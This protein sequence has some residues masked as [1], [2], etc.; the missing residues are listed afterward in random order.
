MVEFYDL[1]GYLGNV[2]ALFFFF[3]PVKDMILLFKGPLDVNKIAY[4]F[5]IFNVLNCE[6]W[7]AY[8]LLPTV[9]KIPIYL[10]NSIGN[11]NIYQRYNCQPCLPCHLLLVQIQRKHFEDFVNFDYITFNL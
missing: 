5:F 1:V 8:G 2:F 3:S 6:L 4:L 9:M 10:C 7:V 11:Y